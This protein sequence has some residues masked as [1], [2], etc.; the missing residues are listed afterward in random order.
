MGGEDV[1]YTMRDSQEIMRTYFNKSFKQIVSVGGGAK[2]K[3]WLQMQADIRDV[4]LERYYP[5]V[6]NNA[7]EFKAIAAA[8][9]ENFVN[10]DGDD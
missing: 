9:T 4:N 5:P 1:K 3:D 2:N 6:V 10:Y 7:K 8:K